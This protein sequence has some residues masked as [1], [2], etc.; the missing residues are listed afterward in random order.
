MPAPY[1]TYPTEYFDLIDRACA[2]SP[3]APVRLG[4]F[5]TYGDASNAR[6]TFYRFRKALGAADAEDT[7]ARDAARRA[8]QI[9]VGVEPREPHPHP[10]FDLV[11]KTAPLLAALRK[12]AQDA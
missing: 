6:R 1:D 12:E 3:E 5:S 2:A 9:A 7:Y 8:E 11:F 10:A 4:P